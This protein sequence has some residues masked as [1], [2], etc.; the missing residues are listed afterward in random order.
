MPYELTRTFEFSAAHF[1]PEA[2]RGHKC[3]AAH[4]HNFVVEVTVRGTPDPRTGWVIDFGEIKGI[5]GPL[6]D[7]LDHRTLNEI[8]GLENATSEVLA[9]WIWDRLKPGLPGLSRI[10]VSET[11]AA[12]CTYWGE[13]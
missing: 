9:R 3:R 7:E 10:T 8:P 11:P 12:R 13:E 1:L 2:G 4:G 5:V 6:I